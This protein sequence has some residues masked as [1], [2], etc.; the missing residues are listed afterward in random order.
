MCLLWIHTNLYTKASEIHVYDRFFYISFIVIGVIALSFFRYA[1]KKIHE[2]VARL[3]ENRERFV[4]H[5]HHQHLR[6]LENSF[7][8]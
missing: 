1:Y 7:L 2:D 3:T 5:L 6:K 4:P 8:F